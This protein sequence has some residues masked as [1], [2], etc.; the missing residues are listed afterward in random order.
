MTEF[1][2]LMAVMS[3]GFGFN[4]CVAPFLNICVLNLPQGIKDRECWR[5]LELGQRC[6]TR[7]RQRETKSGL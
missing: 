7:V 1:L 4:L 2:G 6:C 5:W 3:E